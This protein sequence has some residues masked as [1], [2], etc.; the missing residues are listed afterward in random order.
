MKNLNNLK[1]IL[2]KHQTKKQFQYSLE[3]EKDQIAIWDNRS[4]LHQVTTFNDNNKVHRII[5]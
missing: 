2:F 5:I 3:W 4:M 1:N